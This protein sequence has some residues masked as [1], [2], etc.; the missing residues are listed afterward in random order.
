MA[1]GGFATQHGVL[2]TT[3]PTMA[4]PSLIAKETPATG[5]FSTAILRIPTKN[6]SNTGTNE[7]I[8][9]YT[10]KTTTVHASITTAG[11]LSISATLVY[12]V[13]IN[14]FSYTCITMK[15]VAVVLSSATPYTS[16][17]GKVTVLNTTIDIPG[18]SSTN[19][20]LAAG[21]LTTAFSGPGGAIQLTLQGELVVPP[22]ATSTTTTLTATPASPQVQGT[23]VTLKATV[24]KTTGALATAATGNVKFRSGTTTVLAVVTVSGGS[25]DYTTSSL[26]AGT[27][28]LTA[29]YSGGGGYAGST[30]PALTYVIGTAPKVTV[31]GLPATVH[32]NSTTTHPFTV[33]VTNPSNGG[34]LTH[35]FL[36]V[37]LSG[38]NHLTPTFVTVQYEDTSGTWCSLAHFSGF[39]TVNGYIPEVGSTC[40]PTYPASFALS[41]PGSLTVHLRVSYPTVTGILFYGKQTVTATVYTG[42][43]SVSACTSVAPLTGTAAP[44]GSDSTELVPPSPL[45]STITDLATRPATSTVRKTFDV[46]LESTV[47]PKATLTAYGLPAPTG[48]VKYEFNTTATEV[49]T[50]TLDHPNGYVNHTSFNLYNS[51]HLKTGTNTVTRTYSGDQ[52][53]ASSTLTQSF[54]VTGTVPTGTP[55][56]CALRSS[57]GSAVD[58]N[59]YVTASGTVPAARLD[60][61]TATVAVT[62]SSVTLT[63]DPVVDATTYNTSQSAAALTFA[64]GKPSVVTSGPITFTGTT[65]EA[66]AVVGTW[67]GLSVT[68]PMAS[69][70][71][72]GTKAVTTEKG[73]SFTGGFNSWTC[74]PATAGSPA[75]VGTTEVG[76]TVLSVSPTGT[77][78]AGSPVTLS[79]TVFPKPSAT[80]AAG[81]VT[82]LDGNTALGSVTVGA[83]GTAEI[84]TSTLSI[85]SHSIHAQWTGNGTPTVPANTSNAVTVRII[86]SG[87]KTTTKTT[88]IGKGYWEVASDGGLFSFGNAAFYGSMGG[89][90]LNEPIV[91]IASTPTGKGYWE[92]AS[93]GGLFSFGNAAF[94]GS[95]GGKPLNEPIVGIASTL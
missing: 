26:K 10:A 5:S 59:A 70:L 90:P 29:V 33:V 62:N 51:L 31:S 49:V 38:I 83:G 95:M 64:N 11:E 27:H 15:P 63:V 67:S 81:K 39:T 50:S 12:Q 40:S 16:T 78:T 44:S 4:T 48:T 6:E 17:S 79:V 91:G 56:V 52:V 85:G 93:D 37:A 82:F 28:K 1:S 60:Q 54:T 68:V 21:P 9:I 32:P 13:N 73:V 92:V 89:K 3:L 76:G 84:S 24:K 42:T 88:E 69:G 18:F 34:R 57:L 74:S 20:G 8:L 55:F 72:P 46:A 77:A 23:P 71:S 75:V 30:S 35:L 86:A 61:G 45:G 87:T 58:V 66:T 43:C 80:S 41:A 94:Y 7:T 36:K 19:C 25:A 47:R 65:R 2:T 22:P 53:Y 14:T